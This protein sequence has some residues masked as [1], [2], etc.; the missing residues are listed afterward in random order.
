MKKFLCLTIAI[1]LMFAVVIPVGAVQSQYQDKATYSFEDT[2]K[3]V[4][5]AEGGTGPWAGFGPNNTTW[6][7]GTDATGSTDIAGTFKLSD[8]ESYRGKYSLSY[9]LNGGY[10]H[11]WPVWDIEGKDTR[12]PR[13]ITLKFYVFVPTGSPFA[14]F[15]KITKDDAGGNGWVIPDEDNTFAITPDTL[16]TWQQVNFTLP[17]YPTDAVMLQT[18]MDTTITWDKTVPV[19][20]IDSIEVYAK[21][22]TMYPQIDGK[23][24]DGLSE[25]PAVVN[26][27]GVTLD[28]TKKELK[29]GESFTLAATIAPADAT[30]KDYTWSTSSAGIATVENGKVTAKGPGTATITVTTKDGN[31]AAT[32]VITVPEPPADLTWI[33]YTIGGAVLLIIIVVVILI[34]SKKKKKV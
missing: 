34:I 31:K 24:W 28:Q 33:Y 30:T 4:A 16:D 21:D 9:N 20:Y 25:P 18:A 11:F 32:C 22:G 8:K 23:V 29:I 5:W 10:I 19:L 3:W 2:S 7:F 14:N 13:G 15:V 12:I 26:V 27:T 17:D 6:I 1:V